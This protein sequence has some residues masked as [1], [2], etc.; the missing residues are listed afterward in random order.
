MERMFHFLRHGSSHT[1]TRV[2]SRGEAVA[3]DADLRRRLHGPEESADERS[4]RDAGLPRGDQANVDADVIAG[5]S[6]DRGRLVAGDFTRVI[7]FSGTNRFVSYTLLR[8]QSSRRLLHE[9]QYLINCIAIQHKCDKLTDR[10]YISESKGVLFVSWIYYENLSE[11]CKCGNVQSRRYVRYFIVVHLPKCS[12][13]CGV[14]KRSRVVTCVT[15][16][17]PCELSE[18]PEVHETCDLG[19]CLAKSTPLNV[20]SAK[21]Q[22]PQWLFTEWSDQVGAFRLL[23]YRLF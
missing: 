18:K 9:L 5:T 16:G 13:S 3:N 20:V 17:A 11:L 1:G 23:V 8:K 15:L 22:S 2:R 19:P 7:C 4:V 14:G 21:L 12:T 10:Q 6:M